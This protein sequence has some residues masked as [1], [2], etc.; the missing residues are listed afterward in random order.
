MVKNN[1]YNIHYYFL[2]TVIVL[3]FLI[4]NNWTDNILHALLTHQEEKVIYLEYNLIC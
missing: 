4:G 1:E 3:V 2:E